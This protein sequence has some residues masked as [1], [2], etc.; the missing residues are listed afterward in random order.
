MDKYD[1]VLAA[2]ICFGSLAIVV[3]SSWR[4]REI[5]RPESPRTQKTP[6]IEDLSGGPDD[7]WE[8]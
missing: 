2:F 6:L 3:V 4:S 1:G 7:I 8:E 5:K